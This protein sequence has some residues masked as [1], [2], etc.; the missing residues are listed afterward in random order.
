MWEA[1]ELTDISPPAR[2]PGHI[3]CPF[4]EEDTPSCAVWEDHFHCYGCGRGG[5]P[6]AFIAHVFAKGDDGGE[7]GPV[8]FSMA[9]K[10]INH[11]LDP[12]GRPEAPVRK[13][14]VLEDLTGRFE[15]ETC[16]Y[17]ALAPAVLHEFIEKKWPH[18]ERSWLVQVFDVGWN[19]NALWIPHYDAGRKTVRGIKTRSLYTGNKKSVTGSCFTTGLY[20]QLH[21]CFYEPGK[22]AVLTE[23]ESDCWTMTWHLQADP[24][25]NVYAMPSGSSTWN[26]SFTEELAQYPQVF[27]LLDPDPAGRKATEVVTAQLEAA[28]VAVTDLSVQLTEGSDATACYLDGWRPS[29]S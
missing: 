26:R 27:L 8:H 21:G 12:E 24:Y 28:G 13:E 10:L 25:K 5:S 22:R 17:R 3:P 6:L 19:A 11:T 18:L 20:R 23:G 15:M 29:F 1:L 16:A 14:K 4:H 7:P 2:M 9:G